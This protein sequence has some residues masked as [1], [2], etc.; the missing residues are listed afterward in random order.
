MN[1]ANTKDQPRY[2]PTLAIQS[3]DPFSKSDSIKVISAVIVQNETVADE[4]ILYFEA[5]TPLASRKYKAS[6]KV[7]CASMY[8]LDWFKLNFPNTPF[9]VY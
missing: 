4:V 1:Q 7:T 9:E 5:T 2:H 8:G 6:A 3:G